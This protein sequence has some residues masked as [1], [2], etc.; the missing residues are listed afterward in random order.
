MPGKPRLLF[1]GM[2]HVCPLG[3]HVISHNNPFH[4]VRVHH[5]SM[6]TELFMYVQQHVTGKPGKMCFVLIFLNCIFHWRVTALQYCVG[7]CCISEWISLRYTY[8]PWRRKW[9]PTPVFLPGES[10][11]QRTLAGYSLWDGRVGPDL[12]TKLYIRPLPF[13][14]PSHLLPHP[15]PEVVT[16][17]QF[18]FPESCS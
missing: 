17:P 2:F 6:E 8:V 15:T 9:Q 11:G 14:L 7:F 4:L 10:H 13:G 16:E 12:R 1:N 3:K 5:K 18:E